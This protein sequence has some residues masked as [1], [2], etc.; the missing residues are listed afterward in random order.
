MVLRK[1]TAAPW[2]WRTSR[3][4]MNLS[5]V[6]VFMQLNFKLKL[7]SVQENL[8]S[9][10]SPVFIVA[11]TSESLPA[12]KKNLVTSAYQHLPTP[13]NA[14]RAVTGRLLSSGLV[15]IIQRFRCAAPRGASRQPGVQKV[16]NWRSVF[17]VVPL[18][19]LHFE[20][21]H[22]RSYTLIKSSK[23]MKHND[24]ALPLLPH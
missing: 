21:A 15:H 7:K 12:A 20:T 11:Q 24:Y 13:T 9:C 16:R 6:T 8:A 3:R 18:W 1:S 22:L 2:L 14:Y 23:A 19:K 4:V 10:A 5:I 17:P